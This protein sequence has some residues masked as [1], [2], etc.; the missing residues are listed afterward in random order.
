MKKW[1]KAGRFL[2]SMKFAILLLLILILA[3]ILGS[4]IPQGELEAYYTGYY[5]KRTGWLIL[6]TGL[7]DVFHSW[8]FVGL[9]AFLCINL[10]GCNLLHFPKLIHR[11]KSGFT[12]EK[13]RTDQAK[14]SEPELIWQEAPDELFIRMGFTRIQKTTDPDGRAVSYAVK[15][16][17]GI[18]GAWLTHLGMLI[19]ILGFSLGQM[20]TTKYSVYGIPGQT[21]QIGDTPYELTIDDFRITMREDDTVDQYT[22]WLTM[23]DTRTGESRSGQASVNV[24]VS[25]FGMK[26]YQ[27]S[28]GWAATVEIWKEE[29]KLQEEIL[30]AGEHTSFAD[31]PDLV[32]AF[33]A[34][35][36]DYMKGSNGMPATASSEL[37]HPAYLYTLYYQEGV[38][39]MNVL[40]DG[41]KI[42]VD[43]Y[44]I[45]FHSPQSYTFIQIKH[46]PF[47]WLALA[48]GVVILAAL[49]LAFYVRTEELWAV[50]LDDGTWAVSGESK[51]SGPLFH[52]KLQNTAKELK[53]EGKN[54][55]QGESGK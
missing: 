34:F 2:F 36:P 40:Q 35:Y 55:T 12:P 19:I 50:A 53:N 51:K 6:L 4:V 25:L 32:L 23:T 43:D 54:R 49:I 52:E 46:D 39:G 14:T 7:D 21:K 18:W 3:C 27:N 9:T 10:L 47:T 24:P 15:N 22:A 20:F 45:L 30:C 42:T 8:W 26:L 44:S 5:P 31:E 11:W 16:R 17:I 1:K 41:E 37:N 48:G 38:V 33:N 13:I 29:E 28:T